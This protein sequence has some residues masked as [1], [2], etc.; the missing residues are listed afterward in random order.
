MAHIIS[1]MVDFSG[2]PRKKRIEDGTHH[3]LDGE[4]SRRTQK[5]RVDEGTHNFLDSEFQRQSS[6][7][8]SR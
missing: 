8:T 6:E 3:F 2:A 5:K 1:L 7:K 4:I